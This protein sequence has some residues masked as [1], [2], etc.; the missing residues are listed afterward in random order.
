[1]QAVFAPACFGLTNDNLPLA[2]FDAGM[3]EAVMAQ[4]GNCATQ[5][6]L[7]RAATSLW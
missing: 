3:V 4:N 6:P 2:I 7:R 1:L 5:K